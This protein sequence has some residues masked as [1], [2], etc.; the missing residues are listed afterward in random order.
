MAHQS[1]VWK[2]KA[3]EGGVR[4]KLVTAV[5][6]SNPARRYRPLG[7]LTSPGLMNRPA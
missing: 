2:D 7:F 1:G 5:R 3:G 4:F 6:R